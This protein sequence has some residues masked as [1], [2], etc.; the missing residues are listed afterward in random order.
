MLCDVSSRSHPNSLL[1]GNVMHKV[2][3]GFCSSSLTS[4]AGM[5]SVKDMKPNDGLLAGKTVALKDMISVKDVPMLMGTE[6]VEGFIPNT[7]AT[8]TRRLLEAGGHITGKAAFDMQV[9]GKRWEEEKVYRVGYAWELAN[10]W[11]QLDYS[12]G[13]RI[14]ER[15]GH[16]H[17]FATW[18]H[19]TCFEAP[20]PQRTTSGQVSQ[21]ALARQQSISSHF[22]NQISTWASTLLHPRFEAHIRKMTESSGLDGLLARFKEQARAAIRAEFRAENE[23]LRVENT[24][25]RDQI[26]KK[27]L[28]LRDVTRERDEYTKKVQSQQLEIKKLR[29][30]MSTE[31]SLRS[32]RI[33]DAQKSPESFDRDIDHKAPPV[34]MDE[35]LDDMYEVAQQSIE[36]QL[37]PAARGVAFLG[38][39]ILEKPGAKFYRDIFDESTSKDEG[40]SLRKAALAFSPSRVKTHS[41]RP[42]KWELGGIGN[43]EAK[44]EVVGSISPEG[45]E[46]QHPKISSPLSSRRTIHRKPQERG[47]NEMPRHNRS[48]AEDKATIKGGEAQTPHQEDDRVLLNSRKRFAEDMAPEEFAAMLPTRRSVCVRCWRTSELCDRGAQCRACQRD[49]VTC[50]HSICGHGLDC[51]HAR[52]AKIH[53]GQYDE[54][55]ED[56]VLDNVDMSGRNKGIDRDER[57]WL[58]RPVRD[59]WRPGVDHGKRN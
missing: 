53:P 30:R 17:A 28:L 51:R 24:M 46:P 3:K 13:S 20:R 9:I 56:W 5:Q 34:S 55:D 40:A 48:P 1:L 49:N 38:F 45:Q 47:R 21:S 23:S 6:F 43:E 7:D 11:K 12:W 58:T 37:G 36:T 19:Y 50:V 26:Q 18:W 57:S 29:G 44:H 52:C 32:G 31:G 41:L 15:D 22:Q 39:R 16:P 42:H 8:V 54:D 27:D 35:H 2:A 33:S 25:L 14:D 59:S 4:D 10:D